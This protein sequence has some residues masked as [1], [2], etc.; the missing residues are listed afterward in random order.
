MLIA[1]SSRTGPLGLPRCG[2]HAA[3]AIGDRARDQ[4]FGDETSFSFAEF[5]QIATPDYQFTIVAAGCRKV[6]GNGDL[7]PSL[8]TCRSARVLENFCHGSSGLCD[9]SR[10]K[11][12]PANLEDF[13]MGNIREPF[14]TA[15]PK[16]KSTSDALTV[17]LDRTTRREI[18]KIA[19]RAKQAET[20]VAAEVLAA[21]VKQQAWFADKIERA[22]KSP[23]VPDRDVEVFFRRWQKPASR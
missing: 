13:S 16:R 21:Y 4:D 22:R 2:L 14:T 6:S 1:V 10:V 18:G 11:L 8:A 23:L 17:E 12:F 5:P 9:V 20:T 3:P 7:S 19:R 15:K